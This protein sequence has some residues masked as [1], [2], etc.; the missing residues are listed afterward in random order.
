MT[1]RLQCN[2]KPS[3][4]GNNNNNGPSSGEPV[5]LDNVAVIGAG[6]MSNV[7]ACEW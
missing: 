1:N 4:V 2:R 7:I 6:V 3:G 5:A